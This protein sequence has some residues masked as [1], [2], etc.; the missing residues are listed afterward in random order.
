MWWAQGPKK[1]S[2]RLVF[3]ALKGQ[4]RTV[5]SIPALASWSSLGGSMRALRPQ[6]A[7]LFLILSVSFDAPALPGRPGLLFLVASK[8]SHST[9]RLPRLASGI[10]REVHQG[11]QALPRVLRGAAPF[12]GVGRRASLAHVALHRALTPA[13]GDIAAPVV[14][15]VTPL[16]HPVRVGIVAAPTAHEVAAVTA[17]GGLVA[18]PGGGNERSVSARHLQHLPLSAK[19]PAALAVVAGPALQGGESILEKAEAF[20]SPTPLGFQ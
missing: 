4:I 8:W 17:T 10:C 14:P 15:A 6:A 11:V 18:L 7:R 13:A 20:F 5:F 16:H 19:Q 12:H 9:S 2:R 3:L 1:H